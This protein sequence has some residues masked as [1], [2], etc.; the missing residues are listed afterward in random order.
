MGAARRPGPRRARPPRR[1]GQQRGDRPALASGRRV[2]GGLE[3]GAGGQ[4][5][6]GDAGHPGAVA[7]HGRRRFDR[8]RRLPCRTDRALHGRL[9]HVEMGTARTD[10]RRES[11]TRRPRDPRQRDPSGVHRDRARGRCASGVSAGQHRRRS[12]GPG[13]ARRTTWRRWSCSCCRT[14]RRSSPARRSRWT[15]ARPATV[16]RSSCATP[17]ASGSRSRARRRGSRRARSRRVPAGSRSG[18]QR[19]GRRGTRTTRRPE[20]RPHG[21]APGAPRTCSTR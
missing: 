7:A 21:R 15:V 13:R 9:H 5:H 18:S 19:S 8:E 10:A 3:P 1:A 12:A 4:R 17:W 11:R 16:G 6:R 20:S 14:S 2:P